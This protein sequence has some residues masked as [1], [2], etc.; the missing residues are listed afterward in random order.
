MPMVTTS[1]QSSSSHGAELDVSEL[2]SEVHDIKFQ[3]GEVHSELTSLRAA[4]A[5]LKRQSEL[6]HEGK[7]YLVHCEE[8]AC[9]HKVACG[10]VSGISVS[11][12]ERYASVSGWSSD[13]AS[14]STCFKSAPFPATVAAKQQPQQQQKQKRKQQKQ[15]LLDMSFDNPSFVIDE[16]KD[17]LRD[18][19]ALHAELVPQ[20]NWSAASHSSTLLSSTLTKVKLGT[21]HGSTAQSYTGSVQEEP[22]VIVQSPRWQRRVTQLEDKLEA[23]TTAESELDASRL[24]IA[25]L[26]PETISQLTHQQ[27]DFL[28]ALSKQ[29][30]RIQQLE[31]MFGNPSGLL[32]ES[33]LPLQSASPPFREFYTF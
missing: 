27:A 10:I 19:K 28:E 16:L 17:S 29:S 18:L 5:E 3:L 21:N 26:H 22:P 14:S 6:P 24:T 25:S 12:A 31:E 32:A 15:N 1:V 33:P 11:D 8:P 13:V 7:C 9:E 30:R 2:S 23:L 4:V 20:E